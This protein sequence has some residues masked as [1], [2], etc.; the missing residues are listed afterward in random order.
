MKARII[1]LLALMALMALM[2]QG[3]VAVR[4]AVLDWWERT[5]VVAVDMGPDPVPR[6]H[7]IA[8][9]DSL[10]SIAREYYPGVDPRKVIHEIR[11]LNPGIDPGRLQIEQRVTLPA[12]VN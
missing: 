12:E 11:E 7:W 3:C 5:D 8:R 1:A 6:Y 9:G 10:W 2:V 4:A